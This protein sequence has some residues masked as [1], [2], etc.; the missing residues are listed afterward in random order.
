VGIFGSAVRANPKGHGSPPQFER[1]TIAPE[2][3]KLAIVKSA[4]QGGGC[5][6]QF[7]VHDESSERTGIVLR[8]RRAK[9]NHEGGLYS[10]V[11]QW[12]GIL[13]VSSRC[14]R[15]QQLWEKMAYPA[16]YNASG[17]SMSPLEEHRLDEHY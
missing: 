2:S 11:M 9:G 1:L 15:F 4:D 17:I 14:S 8:E 6:S 7:T 3:G 5:P 12:D 13:V 10:E 16:Y